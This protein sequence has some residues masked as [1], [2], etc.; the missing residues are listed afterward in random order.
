MPDPDM[1]NMPPASAPLLVPFGLAEAGAP[2]AL[3]PLA[4]DAHDV[5]PTGNEWLSMPDIR[6]SD[7][8]MMSFNVLSKG[9]RGLLQARGPQGRSGSEFAGPRDRNVESVPAD[10][11]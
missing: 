8:S 11:G 5:I 6:A 4:L 7:G 9:Y 10:D 1:T 3:S 2:I